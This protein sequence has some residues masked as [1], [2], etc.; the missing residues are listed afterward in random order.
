MK[1]ISLTGIKPTGTP[2]IGNYLGAIKPAIELAREYKA[3][4]FIADYHALTTVKN[5]GELK[6]LSYEVACTWLALGLNPQEVTFFRQSDIP[7]LFELM[8]I[9]ACLTPKGLLNR[10]HAYKASVDKNIAAGKP[11]DEG[12]NAGLF[13]YPVLMAADIL[14]FR[15][16]VVPV[17]LDQK[18]HVEIARDIAV[19]FN[20]NYKKILTLPEALIQ[21]EVMTVPGVDGRKMSKNYDNTLPIFASPEELRKRVM[22]IV[23]DSRQPSEPKDPDRCNIFAIYRQFASSEAVAAAR[24]Q[25]EQGGKAYSE[26][27]QELY[28]LLNET[29]AE[30]RRKYDDLMSNRDYIDQVLAEGA[31]RARS[32]AVPLM[33]EVRKAVGVGPR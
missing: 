3:F 21:E 33:K 6:H 27:K 23:T 29:F 32:F 8:W 24:R 9:L 16:N 4:Y 13:N 14:L 25:Y 17:G 12:L 11:G 10:A 26:M 22:R 28:E 7:E 31:E 1:K 18:Q 5:G 2:H 15:T 19:S 30:A 20:K